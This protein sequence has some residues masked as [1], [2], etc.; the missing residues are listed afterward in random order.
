M[1][2]N[3][4][5]VVG[6]RRLHQKLERRAQWNAVLVD[7]E[8]RLL[9]VLWASCALVRRRVT[10]WSLIDV[11][12]ERFT[13]EQEDDAPGEKRYT[14]NEFFFLTDPDWF[15]CTHLPDDPLWQLL[16]QPL[17]VVQFESF[18]Y[19]RERFFDLGLTMRND[20]RR[21]CVLTTTDAEVT[22]VF[23]IPASLGARAQFRYMLFRKTAAEVDSDKPAIQTKGCVIYELSATKVR[24]T[25]HMAE[26]GRFRLDIFGRDVDR[27]NGMDLMCSYVIVCDS[28]DGRFLPDDPEI[29]W[30]PGTELDE[31][32]L[33]PAS[34]LEGIVYTDEPELTIRFYKATYKN[35]VFWHCLKHNTINYDTLMSR[36]TL[37][38]CGDDVI[39]VV[40][41]PEPGEYAYKLFSDERNANGD[42]PNVCNYLIRFFR[43]V[44][45]PTP[46]PP[47]RWGILGKGMHA[48]ALEV[49][50]TGLGADGYMKTWKSD[51]RLRFNMSQ[52]KC[53]FFYEIGYL[54]NTLV[55]PAAMVK[56]DVQ[57]SHVIVHLTLDEPGEYGI[58]VFVRHR[59]GSNLLHH[60]HSLL[61]DYVD[62]CIGSDD[63][64]IKDGLRAVNQL[65]VGSP[66]G[67]QLTNGNGIEAVEC[68]DSQGL[69]QLTSAPTL[70]G[71]TERLATEVSLG[72]TNV[73]DGSAEDVTSNATEMSAIAASSEVMPETGTALWRNRA[74]SVREY[75]TKMCIPDGSVTSEE[76]YRMTLPQSERPLVIAAER[77]A[78]QHPVNFIRLQRKKDELFVTLPLA[79]AYVVDVY[80][81]HERC[82]LENLRRVNITRNEKVI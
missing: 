42:I 73:P 24:Y 74:S 75:T 20:S 65:L 77:K 64:H 2:K 23:G 37:R 76:V 55:K 45:P 38:M 57:Q 79:G 14:T 31:V 47:L 63:L 35:L 10:G 49:K 40:R 50:P 33:V 3:G 34:H 12:G 32:G 80:E 51:V 69:N 68:D 59:S 44:S 1:N 30:G 28:T 60:V 72:S 18:F 71:E 17:S 5:Y 82:R 78:A 4:S 11:D 53:E 27:H 67:R 9:D 36:I 22:V 56:V 6:E 7:G 13:E 8:W 19:L 66:D 46:F 43:P 21:R 16:P 70:V 41:L 48:P 29:G 54:H 39:I 25:C 62:M 81:V 58:N 26:V 15:I 61:I 52:S